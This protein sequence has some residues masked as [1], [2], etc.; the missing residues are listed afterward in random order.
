MVAEGYKQTEIG[1]I[2]ND[3]NIKDIKSVTNNIIDYRGVTPKKKGMEW[4]NGNIVALSAG[5]VKNGY[6]ECPQNSRH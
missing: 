3:W 2:P 5:N 1:I 4:G 6:M